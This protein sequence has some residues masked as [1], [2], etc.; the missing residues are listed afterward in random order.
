MVVLLSLLSPVITHCSAAE[1]PDQ[2]RRAHANHP[3]AAARIAP[4]VACIRKLGGTSLYNVV[5]LRQHGGWN[6]E[7]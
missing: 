5:G 3:S 6:L 1:R 4:T 2:A 7:T